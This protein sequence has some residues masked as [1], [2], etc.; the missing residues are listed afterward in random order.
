MEILI[1]GK[2]TTSATAAGVPVLSGAHFS[3]LIG[4]VHNGRVTFW[5]SGGTASAGIE[6]MAELGGTSALKSEINANPNALAVVE[7]S[8]ASGGTA[9]ATVEVAV[10]AA[11]PLVTLVTMVAPRLDWFVGVSGLSLLDA[12]GEWLLQ[13]QVDLFPYDAGT[14]EGTKLS[15]SNP[16]TSPQGMIASLKETGKFSDQPIARLTFDLQLPVLAAL[17]SCDKEKEHELHR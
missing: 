13:H 8:I 17:R 3:P 16:A 14:E 12:Q 11:H 5:S 7:Q 1:E 4:A 6:S 10:T 15:L 2:W 9:T